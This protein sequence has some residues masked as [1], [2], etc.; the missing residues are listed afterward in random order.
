[1]SC[2]IRRKKTAKVRLDQAIGLAFRD[3]DLDDHTR[4][5]FKHLLD[6]V[7]SRTNLLRPTGDGHRHG[8]IGQVMIVSGL[9]ALARHAS[10]WLRPAGE[11]VPS[12]GACAA[13]V[14]VAGRAPL[15]QLPDAGVHG[16]G[17][18]SRQR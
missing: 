11:W 9:V 17:L 6:L 1:M 2:T 10:D 3:G 4:H 15:G 12:V 5:A 14:R 13:A 16:L 7:R 18:V 8:D